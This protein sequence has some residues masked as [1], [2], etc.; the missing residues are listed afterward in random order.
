MP[1]QIKVTFKNFWGLD[2]TKMVKAKLPG[3]ATGTVTDALLRTGVKAVA[4]LVQ[5]GPLL[6]D[7]LNMITPP[8]GAVSILG[9]IPGV[10]IRSPSPDFTIAVGWTGAA[11]AGVQ[12]GGGGGVYFWNKK[13]GGELGT[14]GSVS[15]GMVTNVGVSV[16]GQVCLMFGT[17]AATLAGDSITLGVEMEAGAVSIGGVLILSAPPVT[18]GTW[19]PTIGLSGWTPEVIGIGATLSAGISALPVS[20]SVSPGRTWIKPV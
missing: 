5:R 19:P 12:F 3:I 15:I 18:L 4:P 20:F 17:A 14:Y 1:G 10:K 9:A 2:Y 7:S 11:G 8:A 16:G 13:P 6:N